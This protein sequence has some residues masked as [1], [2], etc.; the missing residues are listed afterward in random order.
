MV[1]SPFLLGIPT[2]L[3]RFSFVF[4]N[5]ARCFRAPE[6]RPRNSRAKQMLG[7]RATEIHFSHGHVA[8]AL[9]S[10]SEAPA[11]NS[12]ARNGRFV[13]A[14]TSTEN[15]AFSPNASERCPGF[16]KHGPATPVKS[17]DLDAQIFLFSSLFFFWRLRLWC[18]L[19]SSLSSSQAVM[20]S[21]KFMEQQMQPTDLPRFFDR[22]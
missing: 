12:R 17:R 18:L 22:C 19:L 1:P 3:N 16:Y 9:L 15:R 5:V 7:K 11:S 21:D 4:D 2:H 6:A 13:I 10:A 20:M 14:K 8:T